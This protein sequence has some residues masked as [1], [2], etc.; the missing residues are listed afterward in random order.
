MIDSEIASLFQKNAVCY[1]DSE[2]DSFISNIFLVQKKGGGQR[3]V[4]NL[5][6]LNNFLRYE[7]FKMEGVH[8][9]KDLL[10]QNDWMVK[11]DLKDAYLTCPVHKEHQKYLRFLWKGKLIQF[12]VMAF[13]L[14]VAP[15]IFT[16]L[17]KTPISVLRRMGIRL[18]IYLDDILL[19]NQS[20]QGV[21]SDLNVAM[22]LLKGLGFLINKEKSEFQPQQRIDF[23]GYTVDSIEMTLSLPRDKVLKIKE[24]C[25]EI[26]SDQSVT[27]RKLAQLIG[28]LTA[29][30]QAIL[31]APLHYRNLQSLKTKALH[32]GGHYDHRVILDQD[33]I[34]EI[35]WW[36]SQ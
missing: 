14:A 34:T 32:S 36:I 8:L 13:G 18:I 17:L 15:R 16:K 6:D 19:M 11:I 29:T 33:S 7:H 2:K 25:K 27:V 9:L 28:K 4:I 21:L 3:P 20:F 12:K 23:L 26:L 22:T 35:N 5:K 1:A 24:T 31:A 10:L 30:N